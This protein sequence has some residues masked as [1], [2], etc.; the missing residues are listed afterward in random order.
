M[1]SKL[2]IEPNPAVGRR[3]TPGFFDDL[4][5]YLETQASFGRPYGLLP[6]ESMP[7]KPIAYLDPPD[8]LRLPVIRAIG[9]NGFPIERL[10]PGFGLMGARPF[11]PR[12][13]PASNGGEELDKND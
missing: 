9:C 11:R 10:Q 13:G 12:F 5:G 7:E 4:M 6:V 8:V 3:L 1:A 2:A